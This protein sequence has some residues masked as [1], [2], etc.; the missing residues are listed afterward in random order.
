MVSEKAL[1]GQEAGGTPAEPDVRCGQVA[2]VLQTWFL[3]Q[4]VD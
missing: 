3:H 1:V 4:W 2:P